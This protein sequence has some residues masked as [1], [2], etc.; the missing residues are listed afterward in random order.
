ACVVAADLVADATDDWL[1]GGRLFSSW[2]VEAISGN[3]TGVPLDPAFAQ[4]CR[5]AFLAQDPGSLAAAFAAE[6]R[7]MGLELATSPVPVLHSHAFYDHV[8]NPL[9]AI[10]HGEARTAV[11]RI[12]LGTIGHGAPANV[13]ERALRDAAIERWLHRWLWGMPNEVDV[14]ARAVL[15]EVPLRAFE[16]DDLTFRWSHAHA[17]GLTTPPSASRLFLHDDFGLRPLPPIG[18]QAVAVVQQTVDPLATDFT[19]AAYLAQPALRDP[20]AVL[21]R[22][23][24]QERMWSCL[25][26]D[27]SQLVRSPTVHLRVLPAGPHWVLAALLTVEAPG[28]GEE[29]LLGMNTLA[30][31]TSA[32]GVAEDHELRLPPVAVRIPQLSTLR[33]RLRNLPLR[34]SPM[35]PV[36][37]CAPIFHDFRV[38]IVQGAPLGSWLDLPLEPVRPRLVV[39]RAAVEL[40]APAPVVATLRGGSLRAGFP[41]F[42]TVGLSGQLPATGYLN[43]VIPIEADWLVLASAGSLQ[44]PIFAGFLGF[45]DGTGNVDATLALGSAAPLPQLLNG[46]ALTFAAFVWDGAWAAT[47]AAATPCDVLLR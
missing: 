19:A 15:A 12:L 16:R 11:H 3:Y 40:A 5:A 25:V 32:A 17:A 10:V 41:Y 4:T 8:A 24:L 2:F 26:G 43:D 6:Q 18:G 44:A 27:E 46:L 34:I 42:V 45:L 29:V 28:T 36:L 35:A 20:A 23:P 13:L 9:S 1:R 33:L 38:D 47:G 7:G 30:S 22:C 14:E 39:D 21:A 37:D 31:L